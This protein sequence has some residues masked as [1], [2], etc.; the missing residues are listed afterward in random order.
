MNEL[1]PREQDL[2]FVNNVYFFFEKEESAPWTKS[3]CLV[4]ERTLL[5]GCDNTAVWLHD[6]FLRKWY[7]THFAT[8]HLK[9]WALGNGP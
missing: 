2:L 7:E 3:T 8:D 5:K 4:K 6:M 9:D 1:L